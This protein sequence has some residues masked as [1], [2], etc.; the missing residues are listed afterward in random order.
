MASGGSGV[1]IKNGINSVA[2]VGACIL[3]LIVIGLIGMMIFYNSELK[4]TESSVASLRN[5]VTQLEASEQKLIL[6]KDRLDKIRDIHEDG[7]ASDE[8]GL[9]KEIAGRDTQGVVFSEVGI[10]SKKFESSVLAENS[11][12]LSAFLSYIT[13]IPNVDKIILSTLSFNPT[14]GYLASLVFQTEA[15]QVKK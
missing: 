9:Y 5:Q 4:Q 10:E 1:K 6:A 2:V 3:V 7:N 13:S 11:S 15:S 8:I 12:S 14:S